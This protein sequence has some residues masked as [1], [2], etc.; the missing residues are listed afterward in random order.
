MS[1]E[2]AESPSVSIRRSQTENYGR[3]T[4]DKILDI[5]NQSRKGEIGL[6][7]ARHKLAKIDPVL[8][9]KDDWLIQKAYMGAKDIGGY[10][11]SGR[12]I[13]EMRNRLSYVSGAK[14]L[15]LFRELIQIGAGLIDDNEGFKTV[16]DIAPEFLDVP[17]ITFPPPYPFSNPRVRALFEHQKNET[18]HDLHLRRDGL[19]FVKDEDQIVEVLK[20][21][22]TGDLPKRRLKSS[23]ATF[24]QGF[25]WTTNH[26]R[27]HE[28]ISRPRA[29][30]DRPRERPKADHRGWDDPRGGP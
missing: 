20:D 27:L 30:R 9:D 2:V 5:Y 25:S 16:S 3:K 13:S 10:P 23:S 22:I 28:Q 1:T 14:A 7:E 12:D 26:Q 6:V 21:H 24:T 11:L 19:Y 8:V 29:Q 18:S 17:G 4:A 15:E